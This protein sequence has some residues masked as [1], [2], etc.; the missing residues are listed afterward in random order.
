VSDLQQHEEIAALIG[1]Y[2]LDA[3]DDEE[4]AA[5]EAHLGICPICR[6]EADSLRATIG[7]MANEGGPAPMAIWERI[8]AALEEQPAPMATVMPA[9]PARRIPIAIASAALAIAAA[10]AIFFGIEVHALDHR[11]GTLTTNI[12]TSSTRAIAT[13]AMLQPGSRQI[14]LKE[15]NGHQLGVIVLLPSGQGVMTALDMRALPANQTYQLWAITGGTPVSLGL[16]GSR[17]GVTLFRVNDHGVF[18]LAV[19]VEPAGGTP[20]PTHPPI[21]VASVA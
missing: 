17:P 13:A 11:I 10:L 20:R 7:M 6:D 5:V 12:E 15:A 19:T 18:D 3:V 4:R 2:V 16:L 14:P 8:E 9:R 1:A 21:A